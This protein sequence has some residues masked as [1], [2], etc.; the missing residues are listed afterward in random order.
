M[1]ETKTSPAEL[2]DTY[3]GAFVSVLI[4]DTDAVGDCA[5]LRREIAGQLDGRTWQLMELDS[6]IKSVIRAK[7]AQRQEDL[8]SVALRMWGETETNAVRHYRSQRDR[9]VGVLETAS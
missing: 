3:A 5:E 6:R 7:L 1:I 2:V 9:L 8:S 4:G